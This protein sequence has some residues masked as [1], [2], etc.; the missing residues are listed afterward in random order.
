MGKAPECTLHVKSM[1]HTQAFRAM[2]QGHTTSAPVRAGW[3]A[4]LDDTCAATQGSAWDAPPGD[5]ICAISCPDDAPPDDAPPDDAPPDD[6]PPDDAPPDD[7]PP[8]D[9]P[10]DD[11]PPDDAPPD[12]KARSDER[13]CG[14]NAHVYVADRALLELEGR[15]P[16]GGQQAEGGEGYY[17]SCRHERH[18]LL[19]AVGAV[20]VCSDTLA[21]RASER[22][23][24]YAGD[25]RQLFCWRELFGGDS[26]CAGMLARRS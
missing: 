7:A 12:D 22:V 23:S 11:A 21:T 2:R 3:A 4:P 25:C 17:A 16:R 10:P 5:E 18:A 19:R 20:H 8:D 15:I 1:Q 14:T 9:A 13:P 24:C 6:A 26:T